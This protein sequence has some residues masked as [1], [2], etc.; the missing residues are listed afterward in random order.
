MQVNSTYFC[1]GSGI[2]SLSR[3]SRSKKSCTSCVVSGPPRLSIMI[4]VLGLRLSFEYDFVLGIKAPGLILEGSGL[5]PLTSRRRRV[6]CVRN[7][8]TDL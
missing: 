8:S 7:I 4:P 6:L 3:K 2:K 5:Y 1:A